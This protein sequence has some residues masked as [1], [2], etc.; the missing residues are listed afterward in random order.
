[1]EMTSSINVRDLILIEAYKLFA[2]KPYDK[3]TIADLEKA[4]ELTR[5]AIFY[6]LKNKEELFIEVCDRFM[7]NANSFKFQ[8]QYSSLPDFFDDYIIWI[9]YEKATLKE[10]GIQNLNY[11][12]VHLTNQAI[13]YYPNFLGK[14]KV[15]QNSL[16]DLFCK[17]IKQAQERGEIKEGLD[18][19]FVSSLFFNVYCG[20]SYNG[21]ILPYGCDTQSL[22]EDFMF[23]YESMIK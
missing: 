3:V 23:I 12:H 16:M 6:Y 13:S 8:E 2:V 22:K 1:M 5:G 9:E 17:H 7:L 10:Y 4:I 19:H 20:V 14:A 11:T 18:L 15:W 21:M